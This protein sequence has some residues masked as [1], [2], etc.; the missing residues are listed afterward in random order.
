MIEAVSKKRDERVFLVGGIVRDLILGINNKD[1]DIVVE[2][3]GIKFALE[4]KDMLG[5]KKVRI[6]EK[7]KTA[8]VVVHDDLKLDIASSRLE[9]YEYPTS[10]PVVEY[11]NIRDDMYRRDF[12]I[13]AMALE[14][15]SYNFGKLIDFYGGY[16]DLVNKKIRTL[17]NLS[18]IE[19]PT[20]IIRAFRF[21]ARYGFELE[22][23]TEIFLKNAIA[24]GFL[25]K[26]SWPRVKQEL[27]ILFSDKNL[28]R[29]M[30]FLNKYKVFGEINPN[31]KYDL[32]IERLET[33]GEL[34]SF[35]KI[36]KWLLV[37]LIILENLE[38]KELDLVFKKF[39]F[40]NKFIEKYDYGI[41][42]REKILEQLESADKNSDIYRA[43]NNISMEI[44]ILIYIQ[45]RKETIKLKV[46]NYIYK[47][48]KIKSLVRGEDLLKDGQLPGIEFKEKLN[49]YFMRQLDMEDPSKEKILKVQ[50]GR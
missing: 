19:D 16:D 34:L 21:A 3:D 22:K 23:D 45:N 26:I 46:E 6:H 4:L 33:L 29:G 50:G 36:Q 20:R 27:E 32:N 5:A 1:I 48:S 35:V 2:G 11:G 25:K 10:L 49:T 17:H 24:D 37:F 43:L 44:I 15:D 8:V 30:E 38:K 41:L 42:I 39:N 40:S 14:I 47:L 31:I 7:F 9:Y 28:T 18:F 12:S 13:N